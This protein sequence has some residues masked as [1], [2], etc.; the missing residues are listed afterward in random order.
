M[1]RL[2]S[3]QLV[4][5]GTNGGYL[6][7]MVIV[8]FVVFGV[9][10][11]STGSVIGT[12]YAKSKGDT[13]ASKAVYAAE[14]GASMALRKLASDVAFLGDGS[15]ASPASYV[16]FGPDA[17]YATSVSGV[18]GDAQRVITSVGVADG[19]GG[20]VNKKK[21]SITLQSKKA[22]MGDSVFIGSGGLS[23]SGTA[24]LLTDRNVYIRGKLTLNS[25][26]SVGSL[27]NPAKLQVA[28]IACSSGGSW[29]VVCPSGEPISAAPSSG[30]V[31]GTV[32]ATGQVTASKIL[33]ASA[34][35]QAAG[36]KASCTAPERP[37][38]MFD[39]KEFMDRVK[40]GT[41]KA[42]EAC[43]FL[44]GYYWGA[45]INVEDKTIVN[46][47]ANVRA[48]Y[49]FSGPPVCKIALKGDVYI[50]GDLTLGQN[51]Y[52]EVADSVGLRRPRVVLEGKLVLE[53]G[54]QGVKP[55]T[56]GT[57][58]YI[59][60]FASKKSGCTTSEDTPRPTN[61][62]CLSASEA[63]DSADPT[64]GSKALECAGGPVAGSYGM[65][66]VIFY[67]YYGIVHCPSNSAGGLTFRA[68]AAQGANV[69]VTPSGGLITGSA[70]SNSPFGTEVYGSEYE[71]VD[72]RQVYD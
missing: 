69:G 15:I 40:T 2:H 72:Y 45:T 53:T 46:S 21:L 31:Y 44:G 50:K 22:F 65:S 49:S 26:A 43:P 9:V 62:T 7:V 6:L 61:A 35:P 10:A 64:T 1:I 8:L 3:Q 58:A 63:Q 29:P 33:P 67:A 51:S 18:A 56:Y 52:I 59:V 42:P 4:Q 17:K 57:S 20:V 68:L 54:S 41:V 60:S 48:T 71:V 70:L 28:N 16:G 36:L 66:G 37:M 12:K 27:S 11:V 24:K 5:K 14:A 39:K 19:P 55:N 30:G 34:T 25:S 32:C 13:Y 23:L 47:S 38:P